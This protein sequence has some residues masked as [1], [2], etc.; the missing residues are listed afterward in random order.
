MNESSSPGITW[1]R[2]HLC[3]ALEGRCAYE[4]LG[5]QYGK[6]FAYIVELDELD[7]IAQLHDCEDDI[8]GALT[9][10][11]SGEET[12][13]SWLLETIPPTRQI[14]FIKGLIYGIASQMGLDMASA[15]SFEEFCAGA[16]PPFPK[17]PD[18]KL[19]S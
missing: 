1:L 15:P 13:P 4:D 9:W 14:G 11:L 6:S 18:R 17:G 2:S 10:L 16:L 3:E 19:Q 12:D 8:N 7:L 5:Y